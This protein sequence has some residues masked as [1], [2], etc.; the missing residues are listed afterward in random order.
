MYFTQHFI[1][2]ES[3]VHTTRSNK[4]A[5][6][7]LKVCSFF[8][9]SSSKRERDEGFAAPEGENVTNKIVIEAERYRVDRMAPVTSVDEPCY[10]SLSASCLLSGGATLSGDAYVAPVRTHA[11]RDTHTRPSLFEAR[12]R[13][14]HAAVSTRRAQVPRSHPAHC[15]S[16]TGLA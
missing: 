3:V 12:P 15:D 13:L 7:R 8:F 11:T 10:R 16:F 1:Y 14:R 5:L 4:S 9:Y 6:S 2:K